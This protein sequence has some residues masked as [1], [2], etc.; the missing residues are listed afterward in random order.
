MS[1][2]VLVV[3]DTEA[4]DK[5]PESS[6]VVQIA[7]RAFDLDKVSVS[8][9]VEP[10]D[11]V[12]QND[13]CKIEEV[14]IRRTAC[15]D[16]AEPLPA[17]W[18]TVVT[19]TTFV[20]YVNTAGIPMTRKAAE[21][22]KITDDM[23]TCAPRFREA[24]TKLFEWIAALGGDEVYLAAHNGAGFD[25]VIMHEEMV[26]NGMRPD[27]VYS[28][29]HHF[30]DSLVFAKKGNMN[31]DGFRMNKRGTAVSNA[32][33]DI[34][35]SLFG[36]ELSGAHDAMIDVNGLTRMVCHERFNGMWS[37]PEAI[38]S[39]KDTMTNLAERHK[40]AVKSDRKTIEAKQIR[41]QGLESFLGQKKTSK[42]DR[43]KRASEISSNASGEYSL[44]DL[45]SVQPKKKK[46][47]K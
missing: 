2:R 13:E 24:C 31:K 35:Y 10:D 45:L 30:V 17:D 18:R 41:S 46:R 4:T 3:F 8:K 34:Y 25:Y 14:R 6:R 44:A 39:L 37:F 29:V 32:Q 40:K 43:R 27:K 22:T 19:K 33:K 23:L 5:F 26:R 47:K 15:K 21:L 28:V 9:T 12:W 42:A 11:A 20:T 38:L 1:K 16:K 7:A 36:E